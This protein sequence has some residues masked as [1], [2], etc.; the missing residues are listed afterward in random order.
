MVDASGSVYIDDLYNNRV[1]K[2]TLSGGNYT[3]SVIVNSGFNSPQN[4]ALDGVGNVYIADSANARV[5]KE[6]LSGGSYTQSV[7][8]N[9]RMACPIQLVWLWM[10]TGT[11]ISDD[12]NS[13]VY[14]ETLSGGRLLPRVWLR[15]TPMTIETSPMAW[16]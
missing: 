10:A 14:L 4:I 1:L 2:E 16:R 8:A 11:Y 7:V 9:T 3:Q 5:L 13:A 12:N 6:T 15:T